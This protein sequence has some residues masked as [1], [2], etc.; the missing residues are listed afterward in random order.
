MALVPLD[1]LFVGTV[2]VYFLVILG[3]GYYGYV[4][5]ED[6]VDFLVAGRSIGPVVGGATL[7]ATQMSAGTLVGTFGIHYLLGFGFI[8]IWPGLWAGWI[9]SILLVAPQMRRFGRLTVPDF[10]AVRYGDDGADG[11]YARAIGAILI[12]IA[13]T[14][15]L[16]AQITA[17]G[18]IFQSLIGVAQEIGMFIMVLTAVIYTSI[19]G[20]RASILTDFVQ[21]VMMATG[22]LVALP[23]SLYFLG[24]LGG[25]NAIFQSFQPSIVGQALSTA[26]IVGF[27][28]AFGF[29]IA[30]APYE[31]TRIYSMRDEKTVRQAIGITLIF[32]AIIGT[33]VALLG[34]SMRVMFPNLST[35]DLASVIMSL[36][37]LGPILGALLIAAVFSAILSTVDS[38]MIVSGAG[39]A[40]DIYGKL[41]N[42]DASDTRM[43]WANRIS[44]AVLGTI[45]FL[46]ALNKGL[47][48]GLVQLI[49]VLQASMM[50]GMFFVPLV[51]G[52]H[53]K[54]A[55]TLGG[56]TA[57]IT[58]FSTVV[59][60]HIG[61]EIM[62][63]VPESLTSV[64]GDPVI[65]G[66]FVSFVTLV[67]VS[68]ATR[69]PSPKCLEPFFKDVTVTD[70][71]SEE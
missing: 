69:T 50:G 14:V 3:I 15:Y 33:S 32:Q 48:G 8:W 24:G 58:G 45:P 36:N 18:L 13:Y 22:V 28:A 59:I 65:P 67:A 51:F 26:D 17:G 63:F 60:W 1:P 43:V 64:I 44:V 37:V 25:I 40:H 34:I 57:M 12:V 30:A 39:L 52:L 10:I 6:E 62:S 68:L 9:V 35:P 16:S 4:K 49:V 29:S 66:V 11:D 27:M 42:P 20:M 41:I 47:L 31:I 23:V 7:S 70:G 21:A 38:V 54:R 61:T 53:W 2:V 71:G 5:T 56:V 19:G 55:N 46:L